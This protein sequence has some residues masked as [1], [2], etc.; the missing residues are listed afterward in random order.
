MVGML[1]FRK[2]QANGS[3]QIIVVGGDW[4]LEAGGSVAR[5][6]CDLRGP[7]GGEGG[8]FLRQGAGDEIHVVART[9][10]GAVPR[11]CVNA[12]LAA[13][14]HHAAGQPF[15]TLKVVQSGIAYPVS[16]GPV[17]SGFAYVTH[18]GIPVRAVA[19]SR[20]GW[21]EAR[22]WMAPRWPGVVNSAAEYDACTPH[23]IYFEDE[24]VDDAALEDLGRSLNGRR[25]FF[26]DGINVTAVKMLG[27]S[28]AFVRTFERG[29]GGL[30]TSC[31]SAM[32]SAAAAIAAGSGGD[33]ARV[34]ELY[35]PAGRVQVSVLEGGAGA[36]CA[37]RCRVGG[38]YHGEVS[39]DGT[40][41]GREV[42]GA[43]DMTAVTALM[44]LER[45][46][47]DQVGAADIYRPMRRA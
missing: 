9:P 16:I 24:V 37:I 38:V 10:D 20:N 15:S 5:A 7:V 18:E 14:F 36:V 4:D 1:S 19:P 40:S 45:R 32:A 17:E 43:M 44:E 31:S 2:V 47:L 35:G 25:E 3:G 27:R 23:L 6:L 34:V 21:A 39:W 30:T 8:V 41:L 11:L 46:E 13:A 22:G 33:A 42:K 29:G 26:R 12:G 28:A